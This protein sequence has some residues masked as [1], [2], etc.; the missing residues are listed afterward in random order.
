VLEAGQS[1]G[2]SAN[3]TKTHLRGLFAKTGTRRQAEL[4]R[5]ATTTLP[6]AVR[7]QA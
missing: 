3:T 5:L 2:V 4:M 1:L 6:P 7:C